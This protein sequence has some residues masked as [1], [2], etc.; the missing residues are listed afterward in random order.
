MWTNRHLYLGQNPF[1]FLLALDRGL[2]DSVTQQ[3]CVLL[4]TQT[5]IKRY[6]L[7]DAVDA[8][9]QTY[10]LGLKEVWEVPAD[11]HQ[12]G[13]VYHTIGYPLDHSTYGGGFLYH[14]DER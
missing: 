10:A 2:S 11:K 5:L 1:V 6:G 7:R 3:C 9:P 14:M 4:S 8:C 13:L 12:P